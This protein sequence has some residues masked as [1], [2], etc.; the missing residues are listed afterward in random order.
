MKVRERLAWF[1][2]G[3]LMGALTLFVMQSREINDLYLKA[4]KSNIII[5][6]LKEENARMYVQL[7]NPSQTLIQS[8]RVECSVPGN[9][10]AV[11]MIGSR[12]AKEQL[13]FLIGRELDILMRSPTIPERILNGQTFMALGRKYQIR[14]TMVVLGEVIYVQLRASPE[15]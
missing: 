10:E 6:E 9:N 3:L 12:Y 1:C 4:A 2:L 15:A 7:H 11:A 5:S 13:T 14:V 8:I